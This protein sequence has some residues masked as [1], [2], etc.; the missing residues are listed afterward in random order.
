MVH[1]AKAGDGWTF[2]GWRK[3]P[4]CGGCGKSVPPASAAPGQTSYRTRP[5][6]CLKCNHPDDKGKRP[7]RVRET[8]ATRA[9]LIAFLKL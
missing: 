1:D 7:G 5:V 6:E 2:E 8:F 9:E 3:C 4:D